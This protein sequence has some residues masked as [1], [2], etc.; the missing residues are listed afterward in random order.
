MG[1]VNKSSLY[2]GKKPLFSEEEDIFVL[3]NQP[4]DSEFF[5]VG[6]FPV[7]S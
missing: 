2:Q 5:K 7:E 6:Y 3:S 4:Q 1:R